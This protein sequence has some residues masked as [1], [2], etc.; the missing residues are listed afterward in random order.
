VFKLPSLLLLLGL[1]SLLLLSQCQEDTKTRGHTLVAD[2]ERLAVSP[3]KT[4]EDI[5]PYDEAIV[6]QE[7]AVKNIIH[8]VLEQ[9]KIR[10]A[11]WTVVG[12][13]AI[14]VDQQLGVRT[15][16]KLAPINQIAGL[17]QVAASDELDVTEDLPRFINLTQTEALGA[18]PEAMRY[19]YRGV[20]SQQMILYWKLRSQLRLLVMGHSHATKGVS[21]KLF[22]PEENGKTPVALNFAP[23][24]SNNAM[25]CLL[26]KEYV[27]P[28][29]KLEW[30]IWVVSARSFNAE[31]K[32]DRKHTEFLESSGWK[33]DQ[34]HKA[35]LWPVPQDAPLVTTAE[36]EQIES[37]FHFDPWGWEG[38]G[39][40][41][42]PEDAAA[43][44]KLIL[45]ELDSTR[46]KWS[47][48]LFSEFSA[49][50]KALND[51]GI[52]VLVLTTPVHPLA[53]TA[54]AADPDGTTHEG[55]AEMVQHMEKLDQELPMTWFRDFNLQGKH[56]FPAADFYDVDHLAR[57]GSYRLTN[58]II[59]WMKTCEKP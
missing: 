35:T 44:R 10:V 26:V 52:R 50:V 56:D 58:R 27:M 22:Y 25:Q 8:G 11:H 36:L 37:I 57:S 13:K 39:K 31:R 1:T 29:P 34:A 59:E 6:W 15:T 41:K 33:H 54:K 19:D 17:D 32:D 42:L 5:L 51:Q 9:K 2:L 21:T 18:S 7:Y 12:G 55:F 49:T 53:A 38:R 16:L 43:Q 28:L 48:P 3:C 24:G 45:S 47:V 14:P 20:F 23:A 30:V 4:P 46:F 40:T